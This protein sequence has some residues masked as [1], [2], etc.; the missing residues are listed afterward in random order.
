MNSYDLT[1]DVLIPAG[2]TIY[3]IRNEQE[4]DIPGESPIISYSNPI[5]SSV[6]P[7]LDDYDLSYKTLYDIYI[8]QK[9]FSQVLFYRTSVN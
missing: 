9:P 3:S 6:Q 7:D 4:S 5:L 1:S 2:S 8:K